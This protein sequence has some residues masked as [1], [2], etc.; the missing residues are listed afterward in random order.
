MDDGIDDTFAS[1]SGAPRP[2]LLTLSSRPQQIIANAMF[3]GVEGPCVFWGMKEIES[4]CTARKRNAFANSEI[5][6]HWKYFAFLP[7]AVMT[8]LYSCFCHDIVFLQEHGVPARSLPHVLITW[9]C[10]V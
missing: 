6:F 8:F 9:A 7:L 5:L 2:R 4:G 1:D 10:S 3:C